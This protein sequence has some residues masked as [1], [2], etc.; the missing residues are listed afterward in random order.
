MKAKTT[1][2]ILLFL[3]S[4]V[5]ANAQYT[6]FYLISNDA[7]KSLVIYKSIKLE[8]KRGGLKRF[9]PDRGYKLMESGSNYFKIEVTSGEYGYVSKRKVFCS[10]TKKEIRKYAAPCPVFKVPSYK[11]SMAKS[12]KKIVKILEAARIND[13][14]KSL[15]SLAEVSEK[16]TNKLESKKLE[17]LTNSI[18]NVA[19]SIETAK[20]AVGSKIG[21]LVTLSFPLLI[22]GFATLLDMNKRRKIVDKNKAALVAE[23]MVNISIIECFMDQF[24]KE[25]S[26]QFYIPNNQINITTNV[27]TKIDFCLLPS[28][29]HAESIILFYANMQRL[30]YF[31]N[32]LANNHFLL[33]R[34]Y[35]SYLYEL[36]HVYLQGAYIKSYL[37]KWKLPKETEKILP[38]GITSEYATNY[39]SNFKGYDAKITPW[40]EC[41][42][43]ELGYG[44]EGVYPDDIR[45][46]LTNLEL[47]EAGAPFLAKFR[48]NSNIIHRAFFKH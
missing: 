26:D 4:S 43:Q 45:A 18:G 1:I 14:T 29:I 37:S 13:I 46:I 40:L 7:N 8:T 48:S 28:Q 22:F 42:D 21:I 9:E 3:L 47:S 2:C 38:K 23:I 10:F 17:E 39:E 19:K 12:S 31:K 41:F 35:L 6:D 32:T 15:N 33:Q 5:S 36:N 11:E 27:Y 34:Q 44:I 30:M 25:Y 16:V 20:S 24:C